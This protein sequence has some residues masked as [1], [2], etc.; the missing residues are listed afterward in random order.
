MEAHGEGEGFP[1]TTTCAGVSDGRESSGWITSEP[2][3]EA[4]DLDKNTWLFQ[5]QLL[6]GHRAAAL[7]VLHCFSWLSGRNTRA[8]HRWLLLSVCSL[9]FPASLHLSI[10]PSLSCSSKFYF[11]A[12]PVIHQDYFSFSCTEKAGYL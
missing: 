5:L 3:N 12:L 7:A 2:E 4:Q 9:S 1:V 6:R 10:L 11:L 8:G